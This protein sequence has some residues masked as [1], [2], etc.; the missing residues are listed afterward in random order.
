VD[1]STSARVFSDRWFCQSVSVCNVSTHPVGGR[2]GRGLCVRISVP[3]RRAATEALAIGDGR[4]RERAILRAA[5][6]KY[7]WRSIALV[8]AKEPGLHDPVFS[9]HHK[10]SAII[11]ISANDAG[12]GDAGVGVV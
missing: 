12:P 4:H 11:T 1:Y 10:I 7:L 3:A 8:V 5:C 6:D 9:Q 2:D